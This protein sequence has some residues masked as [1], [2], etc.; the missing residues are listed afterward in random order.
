MVRDSRLDREPD[1]LI[2]DV[3]L[4]EDDVVSDRVL[5]EE[6]V[7]VV[8]ALLVRDDV[9]VRETVVDAVDDFEGV[10]LRVVVKVVSGEPVIHADRVL[11]C[12]SRPDRVPVAV[13]VADRVDVAV[14]VGIAPQSAKRRPPHVDSYCNATI[15][16]GAAATPLRSPSPG[17]NDIRLRS[18][19]KRRI[20]SWILKISI[21]CLGE[22]KMVPCDTLFW[23]F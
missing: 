9:D 21:S 15:S 17:E 5:V 20:L 12:D 16:V 3:L 11:L 1:A 22:T 18:S 14:S 19:G 2:V 6:R 8:L 23:F 7:D 13:R 4:I 10:A